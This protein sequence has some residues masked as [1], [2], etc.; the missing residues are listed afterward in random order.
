MTS[1]GWSG[2]RRVVIPLGAVI[3][4]VLV[5]VS[6]AVGVT[7]GLSQLPGTAGCVSDLGDSGCAHGV[8][9]STPRA[10]ALS[11][12]GS[13][14]Y[15]A[16]NDTD[17]SGNAVAA[18]VDVFSRDGASGALTQ[19][20]G[21]QG[22]IAGSGDPGTRCALA[23]SGLP[24]VNISS[25]AL[26]VSPDG[27]N[28]YVV[29]S[30]GRGFIGGY[31]TGGQMT[32]FSR[33]PTSGALTQLPLPQGCLN[34]DGILGPGCDS[35]PR[36][37]GTVVSIAIS[38]D[39]S[40]VYTAD[41]QSGG[42]AVFSRN[43]D[44]SLTQLPGTAGCVDDG[45]TNTGNCAVPTGAAAAGL[46][47]IG[48]LAI[49]PDGKFLYA[50]SHGSYASDLGAITVF[51]RAA[52]GSLSQVPQCVSEAPA[53]GCTQGTLIGAVAAITVNAGSV[54][55]RT[56]HSAG[57]SG[58]AAFSRDANTGMISQLASPNG[59][60][61]LGSFAAS[62]T[63]ACTQGPPRDGEFVAPGL[64]LSSDG[65]ALFSSLSDDG[66]IQLN[67]DPSTGILTLLPGSSGCVE[68]STGPCQPGR[69]MTG[70][71]NLAVSS[72]GA[73]VYQSAQDHPSGAVDVIARASP[74]QA[75][76][77]ATS[78]PAVAGSSAAGFAGQVNPEGLPTTAHFEYGLDARYGTVPGAS[79][80]DQSTADQVVGSDSTMHSLTASVSGLVPNA[81]YHVRL[82]AT[83]SAGTT[84]GQDQT[85]MTAADPPPPPPQLGKSVDLTP[86]SGTVLIRLPGAHPAFDSALTKGS[87]FIPLTEARQLPTGSQID[88]RAGTLALVAA[89]TQVG[90]PQSAT[91][92]GGLF[93]VTQAQTGLAKGLTTFALL[94]GDFPGA[95]SFSGCGHATSDNPG[96]AAA[97]PP[98]RV[99]QTLHAQAHGRFRTKGR[100]SAAT[101][102]GTIWDTTDRC[103]GTL[104]VVHRGVVDVTDFGLRKT[105][106]V[107]TGHS[108]LARAKR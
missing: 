7:G 95:P 18:S 79:M 24:S 63:A 12:D 47:G 59:C 106:A 82:V 86:V 16:A 80:Y 91:L 19:L 67:R 72:G 62:T 31:G 23:Q 15:V 104:T 61:Q 52:D 84:A 101:V 30:G 56:Y 69:A 70:G 103:D 35:S 100:Y 48:T 68:A 60:I 5:C 64:A 38:P 14:V 25:N 13:S 94:A 3:V 53:S 58:I 34:P 88:A 20:A 83:N 77:A 66:V 46:K 32:I 29:G 57:G 39:G 50:G 33:N 40:N 21:T 75:P 98:P 6:A 49:S 71:V 26:A 51:S 41:E 73:Q 28:V 45:D 44:G 87:G 108:Y 27:K 11:P 65:T 81:L 54:Y 17:A 92:G 78:T 42:I 8:A 74:M 9:L 93:G 85:F 102:R 10:V 76:V 107:H 55:V 97:A 36:E 43:A 105:I 90:K 1:R 2:R 89:G 99:L 4:L 96:A 37:F 22:C